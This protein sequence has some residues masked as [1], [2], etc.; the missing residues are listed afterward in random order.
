MTALFA[1]Y[2]RAYHAKHDSNPIFDDPLAEQLFSP[3]E[4]AAFERNL[5]QALN[6]F[7]PQAAPSYPEPHRALA[8]VMHRQIGPISL[9]RSR[10]TEDLLEEAVRQGVQQ[11]VVLGAGLDTFAFRR[12]DLL[13][14]L[15]T[16]EVDHPA[17]QADKQRRIARAGWPIPE[18]LHFIPNDFT[19]RNLP[20][21][22]RHS[23]FDP[24]ALTFFSWLGVT[25]Y[26]T[27]KQV[28]DTLRS[29]A[30]FAARGSL[31]VFDYLDA[32]AFVSTSTPQR[33][34][35]ML[36][37]VE[38]T[39]EPMRDGI[40]PSSLT[41]TLAGAGLTLREHLDPAEIQTCYFADRRDAYQA[42]EHVHFA[43]AAI[44]GATPAASAARLS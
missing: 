34:R 17:T 26:L 7:E 31:V 1:G 39:G 5:A 15:R 29:V 28:F 2:A 12:P 32:A 37:A 3:E 14:R 27:V 11:Y 38:S 18:R 21:A 41:A 19:E 10:F 13:K 40:D 22:L 9:S 30:S 36:A 44:S 4:I 43:A 42:F 24:R 25:Y 8:R 35:V 20:S 33:V 23:R 6:F 16:F